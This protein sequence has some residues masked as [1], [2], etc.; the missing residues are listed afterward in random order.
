[1]RHSFQLNMAVNG[2][3]NTRVEAAENCP[4]S[5]SEGDEVFELL[6]DREEQ[7]SSNFAC[8]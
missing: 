8:L 6:N 1:M 7:G 5:V 2:G 3:F 4:S